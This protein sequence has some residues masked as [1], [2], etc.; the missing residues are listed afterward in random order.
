ML[1]Q[2]L[3]PAMVVVEMTAPIRPSAGPRTSQ[4]EP[5]AA[6]RRRIVLVAGIAAAA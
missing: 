6:R 3:T 4:E 1:P 2:I 5:H